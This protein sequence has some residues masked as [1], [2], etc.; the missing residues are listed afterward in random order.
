MDDIPAGV[1]TVADQFLSTLGMPPTV[2]GVVASLIVGWMAGAGCCYVR[3]W[4]SKLD[5]SRAVE[6]ERAR[7]AR[8]LHDSLGATF[9]EISL[10]SSLAED[11]STAEQSKHL[12]TIQHRAKSGAEALVDIVWTIDGE[13][14]SVAKLID[15]ATGFT[16]DYLA[17][18]GIRTKVSR[19]PVNPMTATAKV[20]PEVSR[21]VI[22]AIKEAVHNAARH[23]AADEVEIRFEIRDR[24]LGISVK[25]NGCGTCPQTCETGNSSS[26]RRSG[27]R[28]LHNLQARLESI[29][30]T[31]RIESHPG[32]GTL[33]LMELPLR[34]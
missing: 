15:Q 26:A 25:D 7:I 11:Q 28:G 23:A 33:V 31:L 1:Q 27:G 34:P 16:I 30:G 13:A 17:V 3:R 12:T 32:Q 20:S 18:A 9:A 22:L 5:V 19:P 21:H 10:L 6:F 8:D 2:L 29:G 24:R 14:H 4:T